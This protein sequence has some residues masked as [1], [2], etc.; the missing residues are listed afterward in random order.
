[1]NR[2]PRIRRAAAVLTGLALAVLGLAAAPAAF[3]RVVPPSGSGG[4]TVPAAVPAATRIVV[5]G[6][7][8]GWQIALIAVGA[9][10]IAAAL[11]VL[12]DRG[13]TAHRKTALRTALGAAL[14]GT[15]PGW[16]PWL[17]GVVLR[18]RCSPEALGHAC[19][20]SVI[21]RWCPVPVIPLECQCPR[22]GWE[23]W[24]RQRRPVVSE[25]PTSRR[26]GAS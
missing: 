26:T 25:P 1:M 11:A 17:T 10:L 8:P 18:I 24:Q 7:M 5:V 23:A 3:A 19:V 22:L 14:G 20:M 15:S 4:T 9:A 6:G 16:T 2:I 21:H 13:R 12:A